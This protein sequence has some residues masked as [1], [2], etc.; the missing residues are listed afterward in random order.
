RLTSIARGRFGEPPLLLKTLAT[1]AV[2]LQF[3]EYANQT[4]TGPPNCRAQRYRC[5]YALR[6]ADFHWRS[7]HFSSAKREAHARPERSGDRSGEEECE[8]RR[9]C[10]LLPARSRRPRQG[11]KGGALRNSRVEFRNETGSKRGE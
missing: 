3:K 7:V 4:P 1:G 6:D 5:R 11:K 8:S 9:V 2:A 10:H